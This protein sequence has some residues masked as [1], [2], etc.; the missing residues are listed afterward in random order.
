MQSF[1]LNTISINNT[2]QRKVTAVGFIN[3]YKQILYIERVKYVEKN[4]IQIFNCRFGN[5]KLWNEMNP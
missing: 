3:F 1:M 5:T 2:S 4:Q